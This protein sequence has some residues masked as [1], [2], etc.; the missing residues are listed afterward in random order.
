MT[1]LEEMVELSVTFMFDLLALG[2]VYKYVLLVKS[3]L[4]R[5]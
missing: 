3:S 2:V 1:S 4:L 5:R